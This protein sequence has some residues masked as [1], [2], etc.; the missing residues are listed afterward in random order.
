MSLAEVAPEEAA[1]VTAGAAEG[2]FVVCL[3]GTD[4]KVDSSDEVVLVDEIL[5]DDKVTL[6]DEALTDD[7]ETLIVETV[8]DGEVDEN[9]FVA[10]SGLEMVCEAFVIVEGEENADEIEAVVESVTGAEK[11][12]KTAVVTAVIEVLAGSTEELVLSS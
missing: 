12:T 6:V 1:C 10:L 2:V 3:G 9:E 11:V 4:E 8:A 7:V 5:V